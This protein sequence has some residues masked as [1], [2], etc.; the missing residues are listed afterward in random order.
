MKLNALKYLFIAGF[1]ATGPALAQSPYMEVV[2]LSEGD[3]LNVRSGPGASY[4]DMGDLA[5]HARVP[6][7]GYDPSGT[8]AMIAFGDNIGWV[9]AAYLSTTNGDHTPGSDQNIGPNGEPVPVVYSVTGVS[10]DDVLWVRADPKASAVPL[11][12]LAPGAPVSVFGMASADW[13][14]VWVGQTVGYVNVA[15]LTPGGGVTTP[16][17]LQL[18]ILCRGTEPFWSFDINADRAV[19]YTRMGGGEAQ[20][21]TLTQATASPQTGSYPYTI[22][23]QPFSGVIQQEI[24]SDGMSDTAYPWSILLSAPDEAGDMRTVYGCCALR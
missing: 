10:T 18:D 11:N 19:T 8:W 6:I 4:A 16:S 2:G 5:P 12:A 15:Y 24:C 22:A 21:S 23:A 17:G 14:E 9:S 20:M 3:I 13:A 7:L 1:I